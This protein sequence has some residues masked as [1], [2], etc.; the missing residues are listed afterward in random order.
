MKRKM[1]CDGVSYAF[2]PTNK[3]KTTLI[4]FGFYLP[5]EKQNAAAN[6]LTLELMK[7][8]T[9]EEPETLLFNR[10]LAGLY[11]ASVSTSE[12]K[13]GD[14]QALRLSL[15]FLNDKFSLKGESITNEATKLICDMV[16]GR[17]FNNSDYPQTAFLR[18]KRLLCEYVLAEYNDKR[19]YAR[20]RCEEIV[21]A[22]EPFENSPLGTAEKIE[23]ISAEDIK[24]ALARLL[25]KAF[26]AIQVVG[27][28]EPC[29]FAE[30][31][32]ELIQNVKRE[33]KPFRQDIL[34]SAGEVK[35]VSEKLPVNQGKLVM[36]LRTDKL[37]KKDF[38]TMSVMTDIFGGGPYSLLFNNVREK[39][40]LCYYCAARAVRQKGLIFVESG[41]EQKNIKLA[42]KS[43]L[44]QFESVKNGNFT[45]NDF[46]S[47]VLSLCDAMKTVNS[48]Q[49]A[50]D[51]WY[52]LRSMEENAFSPEGMIEAVKSVTRDD[53]S[54]LAKTFSL[55]TVFTVE[56]KGENE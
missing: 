51:R 30:K 4:S 44:E 56:T 39:Q 3:F 53:V 5:L 18:E 38:A 6:A 32:T 2:I 27:A 54:R 20:A 12:M 1:L 17:Y 43:I 22:G 16:F 14:K 21:S 55:D 40:S 52:S 15:M 34:K 47:S 36:G 46:N 35:R 13:L 25:E 37:D 28:E 23:K 29:G 8:G 24:I 10:R 19:K 48:D 49:E 50:I 7:S 42:E 41:V 45:E 11:G 31:M 26:I 33:Y 9:V